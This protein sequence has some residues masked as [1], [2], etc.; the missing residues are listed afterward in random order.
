MLRI[1]S[2]LAPRTLVRR[3]RRHDCLASPCGVWALDGPVVLPWRERWPRS[4]L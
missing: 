1:D 4:Q 3:W 2:C